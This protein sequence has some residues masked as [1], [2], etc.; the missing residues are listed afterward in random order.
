LDRYAAGCFPTELMARAT[1]AHP[2]GLHMLMLIKRAFDRRRVV[3]KGRQ[4]PVVRVTADLCV[5]WAVSRQTRARILAA[6]EAA[7][8]L[9]VEERRRGASPLVRFAEDV[10]FPSYA[11]PKPLSRVHLGKGVGPS[12][13]VFDPS[14]E[15]N[16]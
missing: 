8:L 15:Q 12:V 11:R 6:L 1:A 16:E 2:S 5:D 9:V 14:E 13:D 10:K 3:A 4:R 7:G